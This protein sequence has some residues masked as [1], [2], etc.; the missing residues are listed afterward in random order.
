VNYTVLVNGAFDSFVL[1]GASSCSFKVMTVPLDLDFDGKPYESSE[2]LAVMVN[3][4]GATAS[5]VRM[6]QVVRLESPTRKMRLLL[7]P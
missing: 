6:G 2:S 7:Q 1:S 3:S 5:A 4:S